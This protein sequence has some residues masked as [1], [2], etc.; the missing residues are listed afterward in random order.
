MPEQAVCCL[1]RAACNLQVREYGQVIADC[2][3]VL[4]LDPDNVKAYLRRGL[5]YEGTG[6]FSKA[7]ADMRDLL[8]IEFASG[9][10]T[11]LG[12]KAKECLERCKKAEPDLRAIPIPVREK[13]VREGATV[14]CAAPTGPG[15]VASC[16]S[17]A[18]SAEKPATEE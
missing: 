1:N 6:R 15:A 12:S 8:S 7:A 11:S 5:A 4:D 16:R 9:G 10:L 13:K 3:Q 18:V 2:G 17:R 14:T